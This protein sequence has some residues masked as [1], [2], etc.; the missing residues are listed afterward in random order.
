MA[1]VEC[2]KRVNRRAVEPEM[3]VAVVVVAVQLSRCCCCHALSLTADRAERGCIRGQ[4]MQVAGIESVVRQGCRLR[5]CVCD[6]GAGESCKFRWLCRNPR[7]AGC[8]CWVRCTAL[9][10][11]AALQ[12]DKIEGKNENWKQSWKLA[13]KLEAGSST[14]FARG[15]AEERRGPVL[16][17]SRRKPGNLGC[18]LGCEV[19]SSSP[20]HGA[21]PSAAQCPVPCALCPVPCAL[22]PVLRCCHDA[23]LPPSH[24][25]LRVCLHSPPPSA[26]RG[27]LQ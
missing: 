20:G 24:P 22:C 1:R 19:G 23:L 27:P 12:T 15:R 13:G 2:L 17:G 26:S 25:P 18:P 9:R 3:A 8:C 5:R 14:Q 21:P 11:T 4:P 16:S 7:H 10:C 6:S